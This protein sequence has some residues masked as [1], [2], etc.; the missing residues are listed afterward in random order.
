VVDKR[1]VDAPDQEQVPIAAE[2]VAANGTGHEIVKCP[3]RAHWWRISPYL[4]GVRDYTLST[5]GRI[6]RAVR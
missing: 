3:E 5:D 4:E 6:E 1:R 2:M